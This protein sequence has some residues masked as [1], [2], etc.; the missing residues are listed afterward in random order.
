MIPNQIWPGR[1]QPE[2]MEKPRG[3]DGQQNCWDTVNP[4]ACVQSDLINLR[5][6]GV[7]FVDYVSLRLL[8]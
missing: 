1:L 4:A 7:L 5:Q 6:F 2:T 8:S 3:Q